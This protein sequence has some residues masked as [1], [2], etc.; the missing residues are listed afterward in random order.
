MAHL[1]ATNH[2]HFFVVCPAS[3]MANWEREIGK[4]SALTSHRVHGNGTRD[5]VLETWAVEGGIA[6]TTFDTLRTLTVPKTPISMLVVDE[7]HYIKN[8]NTVRTKNVL[9]LLRQ[10]GRVILLS[11]TPL[12]NRVAEFTTLV[13][14]LRPDLVAE[15]EASDEHNDEQ[16]FRKLLAPAYLRRNQRDVLK[17]LPEMVAVDEWVEFSNGD[18]NAYLKAV[19]DGHIMRMRRAAFTTAKDSAKLRRLIEIVE[20]SKENGLKVLIFSYFRDVLDMVQEALGDRVVG[21]ITGNTPPPARQ[22]MV[23]AFSEVKGHAVLLSQIEAGGTG[24]NIQAASVVILCEP[25]FKP[26]I[27][28]Q[29]IARAHRMGQN[30]V[31]TVYR[32]L[33]KESVDDALLTRLGMKAR[34]FDR[35]ARTSVVAEATDAAIDTATANSDA[36]LARD[37][38]STERREAAA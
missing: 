8:P 12:E 7:A 26:S 3:V 16:S 35:F 30:R 1:T 6:I 25:Q 29:A 38:I 21:H 36:A 34:L 15:L 33:A 24:L 22:D 4:L 9:T 2:T 37:L 27:E 14:Y 18:R 19:A 31:V 10:S 13:G 28:D 17:E 11:G 20:E 5:S 23:D 32:L